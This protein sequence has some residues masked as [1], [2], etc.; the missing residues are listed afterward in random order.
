MA[1]Y[2]YG[3]SLAM[4]QL[5]FI[6]PV[7]IIISYNVMPTF[8]YTRFINQLS[9]WQHIEKNGLRGVSGLGSGYTIR[10]HGH[11]YFVQFARLR[12]YPTGSPCLK[13]TQTVIAWY[14]ASA[15]IFIMTGLHNDSPLWQQAPN[16]S[17]KYCY[18]SAC[19]AVK[20]L[21]SDLQDK[22]SI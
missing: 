6:N 1:Q 3:M 5:C 12:F 9:P 14:T 22:T 19:C 21:C 2:I 8:P 7:N 15:L 20:T 11:E 13:T 18:V 16:C 10:L 17:D 4:M